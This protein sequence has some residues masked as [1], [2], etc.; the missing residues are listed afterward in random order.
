MDDKLATLMARADGITSAVDALQAQRRRVKDLLEYAATA[1]GTTKRVVICCH[2]E[3]NITL[4]SRGAIDC[5]EAAI[6]AEIEAY[7][8]RL[9]RLLHAVS[10]QASL[11]ATMPLPAG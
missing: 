10:V 9:E 11:S 5:V 2:G 3:T 1:K 8:D 4:E 6:Q 7:E